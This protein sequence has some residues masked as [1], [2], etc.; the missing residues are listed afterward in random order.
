MATDRLT[1]AEVIRLRSP[2]QA[3]LASIWWRAY[4]QP[5]SNFRVTTV[6]G[7][8]L[9]G[10][11]LKRGHDTLLIYCH[12]FLSGKNYF[13]VPRFVEMLAED[14]DTL[15]FD[16]RGHGESEGATTLGEREILDLDAVFEYA[17]HYGYRKIFVMGS[18]M[19]GAVAIRYGAQNPNVA[20]V[21]TMGA[22]ATGDFSKFAAL[23]IKCFRIPGMP[24][25]IHLARQ[26][27]VESIVPHSTPMQV[28]H[29]ISPRPLLLLH[30]ALDP[31]IP[32]S[33]ARKLYQSAGEPKQLV[34]IPRGSHDIPNLNARARDL[35]IGWIQHSSDR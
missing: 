15:A 21:V 29:R 35:I 2:L 6:D 16:F 32:L 13:V 31:L 34:V 26:C 9:R 23:A 19:G 18:S 14:V 28:V 1:P 33:H 7:V 12:G 27:R 3:G 25:L 22:F 30:G 4:T 11:H 8:T 17:R 24:K 20:G 5:H 10:V